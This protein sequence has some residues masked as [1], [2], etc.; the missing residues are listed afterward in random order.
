MKLSQT[1][2]IHICPIKRLYVELDKN[3]PDRKTIA[4]LLSMEDVWHPNLKLLDAFHIMLITTKI[5]IT[6]ELFSMNIIR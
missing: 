1:K 5:Q 3:L 4:I 6:K 2:E